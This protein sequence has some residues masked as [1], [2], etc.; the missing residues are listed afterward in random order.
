MPS[1]IQSSSVVPCAASDNNCSCHRLDAQATFEAAET[2]LEHRRCVPEGNARQASSEVT[3]PSGEAGDRRPRL[4]ESIVRRLVMTP[5]PADVKIGDLDQCCAAA[6]SSA[7]HFGS[8]DGHTK[9][10]EYSEFI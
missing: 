9:K 3:S 10:S 5:G 2:L 8:G 7:Y 4:L 6:A 1:S